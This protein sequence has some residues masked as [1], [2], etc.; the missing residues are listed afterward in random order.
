MIRIIPYYERADDEKKAFEQQYLRMVAAVT[1]F[2]PED[3]LFDD[4]EGLA[5]ISRTPKKRSRKQG[6][7]SID[8]DFTKLLNAYRVT[9]GTDKTEQLQ[10]EAEL[11]ERIIWNYSNDMH[12]FLYGPTGS[13]TLEKGRV[14]PA[15]LRELLLLKLPNGEIPDEFQYQRMRNKEAGSPEKHAKALYEYVFCYDRFA[16]LKPGNG[17]RGI[18]KL[19]EAL[20]IKV[21]PYCNR[22]FTTAVSQK[23]HRVRPQLDHFRNKSRY[24]FLALSINNLVPACGV[25]NLLKL[26]NSFNYAYPYEEGFDDGGFV[27][28]SNIPAEHTV[29][30][31]EGIRIAEED[32]HIQLTCPVPEGTEAA[33]ERCDR[34]K[35][36]IDRLALIELYQSHR[37]YVSFLYRQRYILTDQLARDLY[38]QFPTLFSSQEEVKAVFTLMYTDIGHWPDRPLSKLTH[39]IQTEID[40][41]YAREKRRG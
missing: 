12:R 2:Y 27:F 9:D 17:H 31:L 39:D 37:D 36:S 35:T 32:F 3:V 4:P 7:K 30:A 18:H 10:A 41:L 6:G 21:C 24:P 33:D 22:L 25:C 1:P 34:I 5:A 29:P 26:D 11:A 40:E 19:V 38:E 23:E 13:F 28:Q 20:G 8:T 15:N 14:N 16:L